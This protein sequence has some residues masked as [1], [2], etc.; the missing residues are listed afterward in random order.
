MQ[1]S[2]SNNVP[3]DRIDTGEIRRD[4]S[5]GRP[6][7]RSPKTDGSGRSHGRARRRDKVAQDLFEARVCIVCH[8]IVQD[9]RARA[10]ADASR[11]RRAG[12]HRRRRGCPRRAS[13]T[14]KHRTYKCTDCHD[15]VATSTT[16]GRRRDPRHRDLP[17][18]PRGQLRRGRTRWSRPAIACHGFHLPG[19]PPMQQARRAAG[20]AL[21]TRARRALPYRR[22]AMTLGSRLPPSSRCVA[23]AGCGGGGG[24]SGSADAAAAARRARPR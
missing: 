7:A 15:K 18:V 11:G 5:D 2:R 13:T 21:M 16:S 17:R 1:A 8:E 12:A 6:A 9:G 20:T 10:S 23:L 24:G 19:H 4:D 3:V 22:C 14:S